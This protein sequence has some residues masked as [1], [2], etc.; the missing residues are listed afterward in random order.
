MIKYLH[1]N[2][3]IIHKENKNKSPEDIKQG[4]L[5]SPSLYIYCIKINLSDIDSL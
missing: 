4:R 2:T 3:Q 1:V 5:M